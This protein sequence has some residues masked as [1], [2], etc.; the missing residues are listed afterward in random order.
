MKTVDY[1]G[2]ALVI[3]FR[4]PTADFYPVLNLV[5]ECE[6]RRFDPTSKLWIAL[7][8]QENIDKLVG[9]GF[10]PTP[11]V[12]ELWHNKPVFTRAP[13][14]L[15]DID[16][17]LLHPDMYPYQIDGVRW[18]E[19]HGGSGIV[20]LPV[21]MGKT[22]IA[23]S[24]ARLHKEDR[25]VLV[26]CPACV[27][28]NW[29]RE[30]KK[31]VGEDSLVLGGRSVYRLN[32]YYKWII[33]NYDI[34]LDWA[35]SLHE[36]GF[37]YIIGD[38]SAY[39][40][41]PKANRT[42]AF[43]T[44]ARSI[45][46][47]VL[48]SATP[49]RNR[50]AEFFTALNLIDKKTFPNRHKYLNKF[51]G[52]KYNGWAWEYKGITNEEELFSLVS[53]VMFRRKKEDVFKDLPSKQNII[54]PFALDSKAQKEYNKASREFIEWVHS[55]KAKKRDDGKAH[56]ETLRQLA[57]IGKRNGAIEW[58][59]NFL[60]S[61]EK[62]CVFAWHTNVID[63]IHEAFKKVSVVVDGRT[64]AKQKQANID[65]FQDG[66]T[67]LF[68]GQIT[69]AG[70]G[71]NLTAAS[72]LAIVEFPWTPGDLEQ[73]KG[74]IDRIGQMSPIVSYYYLVGAGTVDED[75][76]LLLDEKSKML[77]Q[78]LDGEVGDNIFGV[79]IY[80]MLADLY[81]KKEAQC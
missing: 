63:D 49:I 65:S 38:E 68:I 3:K 11:A 23:A 45:P 40:N 27:K 22:N 24:Y 80:D 74:R 8:T 28:Y 31:W 30:I 2:E 81:E 78:T 16:Q 77:N 13:D 72:S 76:A 14:A 54:V 6:G 12:K 67:Q 42:K 1:D 18:L 44:L 62:L 56:I 20:G 35:P 32:N 69:A 37:K 73:V 58:I 15:A 64:N 17:S 19:S 75:T 36:H 29:Q 51:C 55:T 7:P 5:K 53:R 39:V 59:E 61:G 79:D 60:E 48:L 41:N 71:I 21:G 9:S 4:V 66:K 25:P 46:K 52:P 70:I 47:K 43:V 34:L 10:A 57:Y 26:V 50:P 33:I